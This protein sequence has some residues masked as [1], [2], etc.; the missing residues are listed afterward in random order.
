MGWSASAATNARRTTADTERSSAAARA[1]N[2]SIR[3]E[4]TFTPRNSVSVLL[5]ISGMSRSRT[6]DG[7][8][9]PPFLGSRPP[10]KYVRSGDPDGNGHYPKAVTGANPP[11]RHPSIYSV[12]KTYCNH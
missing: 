6:V 9:V 4:G 2:A 12:T 7:T 11:G 5:V 3:R 8:N 10:A 1:R